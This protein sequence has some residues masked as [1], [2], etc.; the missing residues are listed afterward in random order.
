MH[1]HTTPKALRHV[2]VLVSL[3][4]SITCSQQPGALL[5]WLALM[6][7]VSGSPASRSCPA[8]LHLSGIRYLFFLTCSQHP[9]SITAMAEYH[10]MLTQLR[11]TTCRPSRAKHSSPSPQLSS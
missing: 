2:V 6:G 1:I 8:A 7:K 11:G 9:I 10:T 5:A 3:P 4:F